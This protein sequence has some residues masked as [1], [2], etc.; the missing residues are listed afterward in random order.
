MGRKKG[1]ESLSPQ[2]STQES[3]V[4]LRVAK[5][6]GRPKDADP[7]SVEGV[8]LCG[9]MLTVVITQGSDDENKAISQEPQSRW[10]VRTC[11]SR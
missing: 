2:A 11:R 8:F 6:V 3:T 5:A 4:L 7:W 10:E 1:G 9:N